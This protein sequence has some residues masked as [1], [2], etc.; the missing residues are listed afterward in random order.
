M[1][2]EELYPDLHRPFPDEVVQEF[3]QGGETLSF[4]AWHR[5][6]QRLNDLVPGRWNSRVSQIL[7]T[8]GNLLL[9]VEVGIDD[10]YHQGTGT[11]VATKKS[12]GG[13]HAEAYSQA[14][15]RA[16]AMHGVGLY[17]YHDET[18]P[19]KQRATYTEKQIELLKKI[20]RSD[21]WTKDDKVKIKQALAQNP[22]KENATAIIEELKATYKRRK[23]AQKEEEDPLADLGAD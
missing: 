6:V 18:P 3:Q 7:E 21:V 16:C 23:K 5:Y 11:A 15:R 14:F 10:V 4:V 1:S 9:T 13:A 22:T 2:Y 12:W 20:C 17:F 19:E 8:G